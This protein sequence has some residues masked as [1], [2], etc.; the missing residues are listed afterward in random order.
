MPFIPTPPPANAT[1]PPPTQPPPLEYLTPLLIVAGI[2][3]GIAILT[4]LV[5]C[6][7]WWCRCCCKRCC[8]GETDPERKF[9]CLRLCQLG[10][11]LLVMAAAFIGLY[12]GRA[13]SISLRNTIDVMVLSL[14]DF[15]RAITVLNQVAARYNFSTGDLTSVQ[16]LISQVSKENPFILSLSHRCAFFSLLPM[17]VLL[18]SISRRW[19]QRASAFSTER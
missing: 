10:M 13:V 6:V 12:G 11:A 14:T 17:W 15:G 1:G 5:A 7:I 3:A 16:S 4:F 19:M 18:S 2:G 9:L 8:L